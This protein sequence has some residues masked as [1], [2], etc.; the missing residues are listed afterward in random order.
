MSKYVTVQITHKEP[1][2]PPVRRSPTGT[3][4]LRM[5]RSR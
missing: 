5:W 4:L 2:A 3:A 1:P